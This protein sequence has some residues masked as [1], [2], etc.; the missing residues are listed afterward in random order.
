MDTI[1][2]ENRD[3]L[4]EDKKSGHTPAATDA[5]RHFVTVGALFVLAGWL[6][7][8]L[9]EWVSLGFTVG[10]IILSSI[11]LHIPPGTRRNVAITAIIAGAV[12]LLVVA[13]FAILLYLI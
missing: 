12:L 9:N 6:T 11:G 8:M 3:I 2:H 13:L 1:T 10:G 7:M 5:K 4:L